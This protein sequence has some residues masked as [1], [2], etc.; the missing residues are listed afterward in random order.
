MKTL[1]KIERF[2]PK[3]L[4]ALT[5]WH[6]ESKDKDKIGIICDGAVR[7]GKT[8]C[9]SLSFILWSFSCF[10]DE[11]FALCGKTISS[12]RRNLVTPLISY[13]NQLG[14]ETKLIFSRNLLEVSLGRVTNRYYLFGG[15]DEGSSALIQGITL[16][17]VLFDEVALMPRSFVEQAIARCSVEGARFWFNCNPEH[18]SHWFYKEWIENPGKKNVHYLHFTM[19]D[20]PSLS[21][22][23]INRYKSLYNGVFYERYVLGKWTALHGA[24]Y[25]MFSNDKHVVSYLPNDLDN[26]II[27]CDYGTTNPSSFGLWGYSAINDC[28]Y[29]VK[30]YYHCSRTTGSVKTDEEYAD[31]LEKLAKGKKITN[32]IID[33]SAASFIQ[34]VRRRNKFTVT[35]AVNN[36]V[37]GIRLVSSNLLLGKLK[38]HES[39]KDSIREFYLYRWNLSA[40]KDQPVKQDDHTMDDIRY[41]ATYAFTNDTGSFYATTTT[42]NN[43]GVI[44]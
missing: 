1:S 8:F 25:P 37:D 6:P 31:Q 16:A 32:V 4:N 40:K 30:E 22:K 38:F 10:N 21:S 41:F 28:W 43:K 9:L 14:F 34:C 39:C 42:R 17:G 36:V 26:F 13:L 35:P 15:K 29:R 23:V 20:N 19:E 24:V 33:P 5:W 3:Q 11:N 27:S 12:V 2:S 44:F 7:S 18:P